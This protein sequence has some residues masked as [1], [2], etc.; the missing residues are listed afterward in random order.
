MPYVFLKIDDRCPG[1]ATM[2][3]F[4]FDRVSDVA[5]VKLVLRYLVFKMNDFQHG[6]LYPMHPLGTSADRP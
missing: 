5:T 2:L 3:P 1:L 4:K 6:Q